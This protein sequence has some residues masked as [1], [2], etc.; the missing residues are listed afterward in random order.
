[1]YQLGL[2]LIKIIDIF[3]Y[4]LL[5]RAILSWFMTPNNPIYSFIIRITEPFLYPIRE[6]LS[7]VFR[8]SFLDFSVIFG[9]LLLWLLKYLVINAI[10]I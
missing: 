6:I 9:F 3:S 7:K 8:N 5:I 2:L 4:I 10:F 1:M